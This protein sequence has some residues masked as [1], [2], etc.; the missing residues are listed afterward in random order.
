MASGQATGAKV[1]V[2]G[3]SPEGKKSRLF[4]GVNEQTGPGGSPD[5]AQAT[6]K[7]NE[8][9]TMPVNP[10]VLRG[11]DKI[12]I[13]ATLT[14]AD[15]LDASDCVFNVPIIRNGAL[16]Y[17]DRTD[18]GFTTDYPASTPADVELQLGSGYTVPEGDSVQVGGGTYFISVENDTA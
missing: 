4:Q 16:E 14:T 2:Y 9:P 11:G 12:I 1:K 10:T 15:G 5:G 18:L 8:L 17:L 6:V 13:F 7:A 3:V